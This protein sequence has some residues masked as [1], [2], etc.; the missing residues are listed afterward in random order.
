[1]PQE[2]AVLG[3]A[4]E[5]QEAR[6]DSFEY[7]ALDEK[8]ERYL[9]EELANM[10]CL[11]EAKDKIGDP[12]A[13]GQVIMDVVWEQFLN[14]VAVTAGED[15][16]KANR[17]LHLDLRDEAH[18]QT[19]ENFAQGK[20]A[21]HNTEIDYQGRYD[22]WQSNFAKDENGNIIMH[23]TRSGREEA[24]LVKGARKPFDQGRPKGSIEKHTDM[25]HTISSGEMIRD[26]ALNAHVPKRKQIEFANSPHNLHEIPS[27][28]NRAKGDKSMTE[29]LDCPNANGQKASEVHN[30]SAEQEATLRKQDAEARPKYGK[31][32]KE[33]EEIS[34]AA[35]KKSQQEEAFRIG[36]SALRGA[37]MT[38]VASLLKEM[39]AKLVKWFKTAERNLS[40]LLDSLQDAI[41]NFVEKIKEHLISA[42]DTV[43]STVL[44]AI[45]GPVFGL[46][47]KV[48]MILKQGW[49]SLKEAVNYLRDPANQDKPWDIRLMEIGK[50]VMAGLTGAG[51]L[52]L[53]EVVEKGLMAIPPFAFEIPLLGSL[54][55]I[56]GMFFGAVT[57]GILGAIAINRIEKMLEKRLKRENVDAQIK[58]GNEILV[59]QR[60]V[61]V[62]NEVK[63]AQIKTTIAKDIHDRHAAAAAVMQTAIE[64]IR[65]NCQT[66]GRAQA[67]LEET[68]KGLDE[69]EAW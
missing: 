11:V 49:S 60:Q 16:I 56:L 20:I 62:V 68:R 9:E 54:A 40:T 12:E 55:G 69:L 22:D 58:K 43:F 10:Q 2:K 31:L 7:D 65:A 52:I 30:I 66:D 59:L 48:W 64:N 1:M 45:V 57:A 4:E 42:A 13:L 46:I 24:T 38:L 39:M 27:R 23:K 35:G 44:T 53:G 5:S 32:K 50:L 37:V 15:F 67:A 21:K 14:Q 33:G 26:P 25:D 28:I 63:L 8:R 3:I 61:Q 19:T 6:M 18:I 29:F 47:K 17:G 41:H 36:K 51:A 34:I